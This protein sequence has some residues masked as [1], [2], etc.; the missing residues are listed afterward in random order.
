M[1]RI[2]PLPQVMNRNVRSFMPTTWNSANRNAERLTNSR[3]AAIEYG[4]PTNQYEFEEPSPVIYEPGDVCDVEGVHQLNISEGNSPMNISAV[5]SHEFTS[6]NYQS[7]MISQKPASNE[8]ANRQ[9]VLKPEGNQR[10]LYQPMLQRQYPRPHLNQAGIEERQ[11]PI[12]QICWNCQ[13]IGHRFLDCPFDELHRFCR[14]CGKD[15]YNIKDCFNCQKRQ[16]G[17]NYRPNVRQ[18]GEMRSGQE[19]H[20]SG[21]QKTTMME[22]ETEQKHH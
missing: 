7:R 2:P 5:T 9:S 19:V 18:Q 10:K 1:N 12:Y 3:V 14:G 22:K 17:L 8:Q 16:S 6:P 20:P 4:Q 11:Q 15:G 13:D 21:I